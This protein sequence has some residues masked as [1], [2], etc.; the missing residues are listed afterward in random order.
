MNAVKNRTRVLI[1]QLPCKLKFATQRTL[2]VRT[3]VTREKIFGECGIK[4]TIRF[5]KIL[6]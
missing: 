1:R 3:F 2:S 5:L 4:A 6:V